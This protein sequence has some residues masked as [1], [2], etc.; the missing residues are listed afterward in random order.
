MSCDES[1]NLKHMKIICAGRH[2]TW[3][4][5]RPGSI[6]N[7][8]DSINSDKFRKFHFNIPIL[9]DS[10][11]LSGDWLIEGDHVFRDM[12][13]ESV[14]LFLREWGERGVRGR[15]CLWT[16]VVGRGGDSTRESLCGCVRVCEMC[17]LK[18]SSTH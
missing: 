14:G 18:H 1:S 5:M 6:L 15:G 13:R 10:M 7:T 11:R 3:S 9:G 17:L 12:R 16:G 4:W 8:S 2:G